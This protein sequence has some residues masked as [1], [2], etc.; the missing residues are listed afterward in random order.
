MSEQSRIPDAKFMSAEAVVDVLKNGPAPEAAQ[1]T[2]WKKILKK[3]FKRKSNKVAD[4]ALEQTIAYLKGEQADPSP[5]HRY[6]GE[7]QKPSENKTKAA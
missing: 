2:S 7:P 5:E 3:L 6:Q 4:P 1:K